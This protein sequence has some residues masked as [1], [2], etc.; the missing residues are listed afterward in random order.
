MFTQTKPSAPSPRTILAWPLT[1]S[2]LESPVIPNSYSDPEGSP[3]KPGR[4]LKRKADL[5]ADAE[6][7]QSSSPRKIARTESTE[8]IV[9][10]S[11][12]FAMMMANRQ[13]AD[14]K[15]E[16]HRQRKIAEEELEAIEKE[17][18]AGEADES[19]DELDFGLGKTQKT[20][21]EDVQGDEPTAEDKA[22]V[23]DRVLGAHELKEEA[24]IEKHK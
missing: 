14:A 18:V 19:D 10:P 13:F 21:D 23:D 24:V 22:M 16:K 11:N 9:G 1:P 12:A 17:F 20:D 3:R 4:G 7:D 2:P 5:E 6:A 8:N 15:K